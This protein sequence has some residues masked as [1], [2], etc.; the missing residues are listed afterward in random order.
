MRRRA[1]VARL[2]AVLCLGLGLSGA[3]VSA[4][5]VEEFP[6]PEGLR[7]AAA[8]WM[9][10]YLEVTTRGGLLHDSRPL[11]LAYETIRC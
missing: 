8:F 5:R 2:L 1:R 7:T 11:G 3:S 9:R 6:Q 4:P 10:V